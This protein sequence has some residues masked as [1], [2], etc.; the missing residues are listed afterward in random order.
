MGLL[1]FLGG[2]NPK[3]GFVFGHERQYVDPK[4]YGYHSVQF[5]L[6]EATAA[7][8]SLDGTKALSSEIRGRFKAY[9][10]PIHMIFMCIGAATYFAYASYVLRVP[11]DVLDEVIDGLKLGLSDLTDQNGR[12]E[13]TVVNHLLST[14]DMFAKVILVELSSPRD[15]QPGVFR[16][17]A[18]PTATAA[19]TLVARYYGEG[20]PLEISAT[21]GLVLQHIFADGWVTLMRLLKDEMRLE[22][23]A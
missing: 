17:N 5:A 10:R 9:V 7:Y 16:P 23:V 21:D 11:Q 12:L 20:K 13:S 1:D 15:H 2:K 19:L 3:R 8:T 22:Y 6:K 4:E 14:I 18:G